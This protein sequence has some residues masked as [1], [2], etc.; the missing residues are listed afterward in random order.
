[1]RRLLLLVPLLAACGPMSPEA[2]A[3]TCEARAR[4]ATGP[5]GEIYMGISNTGPRVGGSI[6]IT[7]DYVR[8]RDPYLLYDQCVRARS[9]QGPIRPLDLTP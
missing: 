4:A 7:S 3:R 6:G 1:M 2:A 5:T 8:G 9:G